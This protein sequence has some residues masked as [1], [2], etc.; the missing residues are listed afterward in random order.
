[1]R[2]FKPTLTVNSLHAVLTVVAAYPKPVSFKDFAHRTGQA[3]NNAAIQAAQLSE[4]RGQQ[5]GLGL[6]CRVPGD[7]R[8]QKMLL[9][10]SDG[11]KIAL[12]LTAKPGVCDGD[13]VDQDFLSSTILPVLDLSRQEVPHLA[14]GTLCVLLAVA[15]YGERFGARGER[16]GWIS[17]KLGVSNL[18]KHFAKL[19]RPDDGRPAL[20][21]LIENQENAR[22]TLPKLTERGLTIVANMAALLRHKAPDPVRY[23]KEDKLQAAKSADDVQYFSDEDFNFSEIEF[24]KPGDDSQDSSDQREVS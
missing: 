10:T 5:P 14:L 2:R 24:L 4:G 17:E 19:A 21:E 6:L 16:S 9:P 11:L 3:Y 23:P 22:I 20:I 7:D 12:E 13:R 1:M 18:P 8:K 15:Q